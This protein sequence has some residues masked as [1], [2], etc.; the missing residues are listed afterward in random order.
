MRTLGYRNSIGSDRN[1]RR[2]KDFCCSQGGWSCHSKHFRK[3]MICLIQRCLERSSVTVVSENTSQEALE[4]Y[5]I[6]RTPN[7]TR[8]LH[9]KKNIK[10][11][12][13]RVPKTTTVRSARRGCFRSEA[14]ELRPKGHEASFN[15]AIIR[16]WSQFISAEPL[17]HRAGLYFCVPRV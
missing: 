5:P 1:E 2:D 14:S 10:E 11:A 13:F 16:I 17:P 15:F 9:S 8:N 4:P 7:N 3:S 12:T 6:L